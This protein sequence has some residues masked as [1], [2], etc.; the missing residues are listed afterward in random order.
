MSWKIN[1]IESCCVKRWISSTTKYFEIFIVWL[2]CLY[3]RLNVLLML[4]WCL[5]S[6]CSLN[7]C[8][9]VCD[10][11]WW[12]FKACMLPLPAPDISDSSGH[13]AA[14]ILNESRLVDLR[15]IIWCDSF[16][17]ISVCTDCVNPAPVTTHRPISGRMEASSLIEITSLF[18]FH[19]C[20]WKKKRLESWYLKECFISSVGAV[21]R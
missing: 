18:S 16:R 11:R 21:E 20:R 9:L 3:L 14:F 17:R 5:Y 2:F 4:K 1:T 13:M 8:L 6:C 19:H 7:L 10:W 15:R 12:W